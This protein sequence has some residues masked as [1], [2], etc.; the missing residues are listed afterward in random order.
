M[1]AAHDHGMTRTAVWPCLV[2]RDAPAAIAFLRDAFGFEPR[3]VYRREG[4]PEIVEHAELRWPGGG[5]VMLGTHAKDDRPFSQRAPGTGVTYVVCDDVESL[6]AR[7]IAAGATA[8]RP[9]ED[10]SYGSRDFAVRDPEG[11]IWSFGTYAGHEGE[12]VDG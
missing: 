3:A 7:A 2:Y 1:A 6:H 4:A 10:Q 9:L 8:L 5:G 12:P 11:N